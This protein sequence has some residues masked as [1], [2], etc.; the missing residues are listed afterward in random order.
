[1]TAIDLNADVGESPA[2]HGAGAGAGADSGLLG[3]VTSVHVACGFHAG[4]SEVM[5]RMAGRAASAGVNVGAH[6]SY[7]DPEGFGRRPMSVPVERVVDDVR[8]QIGA[9][10]AL[11]R[12][13]GTRLS[14][15]KAPDARRDRGGVPPPAL[16]GTAGPRGPWR[17][18]ERATGCLLRGEV[19]GQERQ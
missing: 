16:A 2:P 9:L 3:L 8:Y 18:C 15:V 14:S 13:E 19:P 1:M 17:G 5:R 7:P 11:A 10:D 4:D 12:V 6:P